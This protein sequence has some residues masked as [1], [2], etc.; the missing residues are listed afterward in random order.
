MITCENV[1]RGAGG[2]RACGTAEQREGGIPV[3]GKD[4]WLVERCGWG[5]K[6]FHLGLEGIVGALGKLEAPM[7]V[8]TVDA[9]AAAQP[10]VVPVHVVGLLKTCLAGVHF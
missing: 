5:S 4:S 1:G 6:G 2:K 3:R 9:E 8:A 10:R 7:A